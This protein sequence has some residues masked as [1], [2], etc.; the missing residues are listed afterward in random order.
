M[1]KLNNEC[2][3]VVCNV[4]IVPFLSRFILLVYVS[5]ET[6][7]TETDKIPPTVDLLIVN[8]ATLCDSIH[9]TVNMIG[10]FISRCLVLGQ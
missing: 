2:V 4:L 8:I 9:I 3:L 10:S 1:N 5:R 7:I 6:I